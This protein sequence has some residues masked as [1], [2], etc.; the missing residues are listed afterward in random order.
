MRLSTFLGHPTYAL[1]VVL[2][3]VLIFSGFGS[4][5]VDRIS[6]LDR[7]TT[8]LLPL[9]V[10][11]GVALVFGFLTPSL[12]DSFAGRTTPVRIGV[13]VGILAPLAFLMGMP[14]SLGMRMAST[15]D[16]SPTAF[17]WGING[18]MSV[19]ASVFATVIAL[20]FGIVWTFLTGIAAYT[21][22]ASCMY[23]LVKRLRNADAPASSNGVAPV[24]DEPDDDAATDTELT[25]AA[26]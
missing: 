11:L 13:A 12:I 2:F 3:T 6:R 20:F 24:A 14:F 15:D 26:T 5:I 21:L 8:L 17:L 9:L 22:A 1:T 19:V 25:P 10:L 7:P 4:M 23:V 16:D 18:A